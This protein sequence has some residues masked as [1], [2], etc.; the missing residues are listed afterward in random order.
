M[1]LLTSKL[2]E[3]FNNRNKITLFLTSVWGIGLCVVFFALV[4]ISLVIELVTV[5]L[6]SVGVIVTAELVTVV[7]TEEVLV[8]FTLLVTTENLVGV[9]W[10]VLGF[11][12]FGGIGL[13]FVL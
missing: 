11:G 2:L 12:G 5:G 7:C 4:V 6:V 3:I 9:G 10:V 13:V 1:I 8:T